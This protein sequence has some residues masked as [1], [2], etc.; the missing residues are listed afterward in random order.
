MT[1]GYLCLDLEEAK[2]LW[3]ALGTRTYILQQQGHSVGRLK[4]LQ[5]R[6][7]NIW[8]ELEHVEKVRRGYTGQ[9]VPRDDAVEGLAP[10]GDFIPDA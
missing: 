9:E 6:V 2:E 1:T 7:D 5:G 8:V 3:L 4:S 10:R